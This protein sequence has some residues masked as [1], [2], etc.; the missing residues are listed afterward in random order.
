MCFHPIPV[1]GDQLYHKQANILEQ[2]ILKFFCFLNNIFICIVSSGQCHPSLAQ[3]WAAPLLHKMDLILGNAGIDCP[4]MPQPLLGSCRL[5]A[6]V[7]S[8]V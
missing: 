5:T 8:C 3:H 2:I 1:Q 7:F 6:L 4:A